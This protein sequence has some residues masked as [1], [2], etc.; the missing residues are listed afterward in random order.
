[1]RSDSACFGSATVNLSAVVT[2]ALISCIHG[3]ID[4]KT[5]LLICAGYPTK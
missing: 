5:L 3:F 1:M 4:E 2:V